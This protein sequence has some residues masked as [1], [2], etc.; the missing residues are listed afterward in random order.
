MLTRLIYPVT[1]H[2]MI[3]MGKL[4]LFHHTVC[5]SSVHIH[6]GGHHDLSIMYFSPL[7]TSKADIYMTI[8]LC[9]VLSA[10]MDD[11]SIGHFIEW[12]A[13]SK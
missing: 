11:Q 6:G 9:S 7:I 3:S 1:T 2:Q 10:G 5:V 12:L 8:T 4:S 13:V